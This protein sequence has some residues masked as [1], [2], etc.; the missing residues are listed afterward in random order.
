M[1]AR[2]RVDV[3]RAQL[4]DADRSRADLLR[5]QALQLHEAERQAIAFEI[6]VLEEQARLQ[7]LQSHESTRSHAAK[8]SYLDAYIAF[9]DSIAKVAD[10]SPLKAQAKCI[11][12]RSQLTFFLNSEYDSLSRDQQDEVQLCFNILTTATSALDYVQASISAATGARALDQ[13][14]ADINA[15][16]RFADQ[17]DGAPSRGMQTLGVALRGIGFSLM[18]LGGLMMLAAVPAATLTIVVGVK[19]TLV[20]VIPLGVVVILAG[21]GL[22]AVLGVA[23]AL[24]ATAGSL[25][26]TNGK[27]VV[28]TYGRHGFSSELGLFAK[29]LNRPYVPAPASSRFVASAPLLLSP[30]SAANF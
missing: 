24:L 13:F 3:L 5:V 9:I 29:T 15:L 17:V 28:N 4:G 1:E 10:A 21:V 27:R 23:G 11:Q 6:R 26:N 18:L 22:A 7:Q 20:G 2:S 12:D 14:H 30:A 8:K 19:F 25:A 16:N